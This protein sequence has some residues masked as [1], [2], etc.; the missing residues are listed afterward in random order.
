MKEMEANKNFIMQK[1]SNYQK[2]YLYEFFVVL[3]CF[4]G[5]LMSDM[6][7]FVILKL[8]AYA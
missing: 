7:H 6:I 1:I 4:C 2:V 3:R 8:Q 5:T